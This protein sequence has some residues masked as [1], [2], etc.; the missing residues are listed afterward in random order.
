MSP[1]KSSKSFNSSAKSS[2]KPRKTSVGNNCNVS[3][4]LNDW[5]NYTTDIPEM[6]NIERFSKKEEGIQLYSSSETNDETDNDFILHLPRH[7]GRFRINRTQ[8]RKLFKNKCPPI[9]RFDLDETY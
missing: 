9:P 8:R 3:V 2:L 5:N 6:F 1:S 4:R 7:V